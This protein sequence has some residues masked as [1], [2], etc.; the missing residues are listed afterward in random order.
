[1][2]ILGGTVF[3]PTGPVAADLVIAD[4]KIS[5]IVAREN[6]SAETTAND[7]I[8]EA[9]GLWI[10]PGGIDAHT[11]FGMPL[12][13]GIQSLGWRESSEAA[14][15]GGTTT[16][17]DF[18]NPNRDESLLTATERW[19][20]AASGACRCDF[21]L[22]TT[23]VQTTDDRLSEI[24]ELVRRGVPTLKGFLAYKGRLMLRPV[25]MRQLMHAVREAGGM[26]LVHAED[27]ELNAAAEQTLLD[28]GR[29][30]P[31]WHP[32]A[33]PPQSEE[34]AVE[35]ALD[36]AL[37]TDCPLTLVHLS[38][39]RSGELLL[40]ARR[41]RDDHGGHTT[42]IGEVCLNHLFADESLYESGHEAALAAI[43]SPPLRAKE[44]GQALLSQLAKGELD[45]LSTDHCE[46][47]LKVKLQRAGGGFPAIPN[48]AG[49]VGER[50]VISHTLGVATGKLNAERW[51]DVCSRR[52]AE[53]MGLGHRKGRIAV[54]FDAD[55]VLFDPAA[56]YRWQ[57]L[58]RS[59]RAANLWAGLPCQ[60]QVR[61][62]WLRGHQ[63]VVDGRLA[64]TQ[65]GGEFLPRALS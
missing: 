40:Q 30:G 52:P 24:P 25:Q 12:G 62:V 26:L 4:G 51:V 16:I 61:Q 5:E 15:L 3:L 38:L 33:H 44:N 59:D 28:L 63:V 54:G 55:L 50:L 35:Q 9:G 1:M 29:T 47:A 42:L 64:L 31:H 20:S 39:A 10:L 37:E 6:G 34:Q 41:R 56:E 22:H 8:V 32:L 19:Q 14:L 36:L 58:G 7:S 21:G 13:N 57:P 18:A 48:G 53:I 65:P 2:R 23:V 17:I 49:A 46:F 60:G 45:L 11:H 43:C 27:G